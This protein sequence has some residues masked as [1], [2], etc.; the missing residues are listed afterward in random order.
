MELPGC[1]PAYTSTLPVTLGYTAW[2]FVRQRAES[3]TVGRKRAPEAIPG[4]VRVSLTESFYDPESRSFR[5]RKGEAIYRIPASIRGTRASI[6]SGVTTP[7][8]V[9]MYSPANPYFFERTI[10]MTGRN[11]CRYS[12]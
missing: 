4:R 1:G 2:S 5:G 12:C 8:P 9:F 10:C 11:P 7:A 6:V 3:R